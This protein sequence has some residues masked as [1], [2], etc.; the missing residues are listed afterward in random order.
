MEPEDKMYEAEDHVGHVSPDDEVDKIEDSLDCLIFTDVRKE[1]QKLKDKGHEAAAVHPIVMLADKWEHFGHG[2]ITMGVEMVE[3]EQEDDDNT[4]DSD[5]SD[6]DEG[7]LLR[8][9]S[10]QSKVT[11]QLFVLPELTPYTL[12][13]KLPE[14]AENHGEER[15]EETVTPATPSSL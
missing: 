8:S 9:N 10:A 3:M 15:T 4:T 7:V 13:E 14:T 5:Q 11:N 6:D 12:E 2:H 1:N